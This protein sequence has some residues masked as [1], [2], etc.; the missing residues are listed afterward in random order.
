MSEANKYK[1]K[2]REEVQ[3]DLGFDH[4]EEWSN[5]IYFGKYSRRLVAWSGASKE[6][7][8]WYNDIWE[9]PETGHVIVYLPVS[10]TEEVE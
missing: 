3:K 2:N 5:H 6:V 9:C 1:Y 8:D 4:I 10:R 7:A